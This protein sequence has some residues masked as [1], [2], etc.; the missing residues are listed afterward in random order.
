MDSQVHCAQQ[1]NK[2]K[3]DPQNDIFLAENADIWLGFNQH[4]GRLIEEMS[5]L[6]N[7]EIRKRILLYKKE[8]LDP[9]PARKSEDDPVGPLYWEDYKYQP[10]QLRNEHID[11]LFTSNVEL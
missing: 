6:S 8:R 7:E 9:T 4:Y 3:Y 10:V 11:G 1:Y 2:W 5:Y